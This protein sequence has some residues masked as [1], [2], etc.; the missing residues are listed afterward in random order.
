MFFG[1]IAA[2]IANT[3]RAKSTDKVHQWYD[4]FP[5]F[6]RVE[7]HQTTEEQIQI[8]EMLN[9]AFGGVDLRDK[10]ASSA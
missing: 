4:F 8:V 7:T 9:A 6:E 3:Q 1:T 2:T 10:K 5:P